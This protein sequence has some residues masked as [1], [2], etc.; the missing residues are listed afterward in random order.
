MR[1]SNVKVSSIR[2]TV[3]GLPDER[4]FEVILER[5]VALARRTLKPLSIVLFKIDRFSSFALYLQEQAMRV[6]SRLVIATLRDS[7]TVCHVGPGAVWAADRIRRAALDT[8]AR[9]V[10]SLSAGVACYP[11]HSM[12]A[13]ELLTLGAAALESALVLGPSRIEVAT[14]L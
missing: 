7:D 8:P 2:E 1:G 6:S 9:D 13:T 14:I 5:K 3:T 11:S 4:I 12:D 10:V